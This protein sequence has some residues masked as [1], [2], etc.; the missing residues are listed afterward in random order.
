MRLVAHRWPSFP[1]RG[2]DG[3]G[4]AT[5]K[6]RAVRSFAIIRPHLR[7]AV[8]FYAA[9]VAA[10]VVPI[11]QV[12]ILRDFI[13]DLGHGG[14]SSHR[15]LALLGVF[16]GVFLLGTFMR[17]LSATLSSSL[18]YQIIAHLQ[19][20]MFD[21]LTSMP[22]VFYTSVRPGAVVSRMTNDVNGIEAMY[23]TVLPAIV[24]SIV[25]IAVSLA[26]IA[27]VEPLMLLLVLLV[28]LCL[29]VVRRAEARINGLINE[30]FEVTKQISSSTESLVS[31]E[32]ILLARQNG[33][34]FDERQKFFALTRASSLTSRRISRAAAT[35]GASYNAAFGVMTALSLGVSV[36][37]AHD[38]RL[39]IGDVVMTTLFVQQLQAPVQSL[40]GT[41]YP[42]LRAKIAFDRVFEVL[43]S[44]VR[45]DPKSLTGRGSAGEPLPSPAPCAPQGS[46]GAPA[47]DV[48]LIL[49]A[50]SF[51]YPPVSTYSI[52]G[53]SH[54]G[55]VISIPWLP[56]TGFSGDDSPVSPER[57]RE[58]LSNFDV[59]VKAGQVKAIVGTSGSG[60]STVA[61]LAA[62]L[63]EPT[64]GRVEIC[65]RDVLTLDHTQLAGLVAFITQDTFVLHDSIRANLRY[66]KPDATDSQILEACEAAQLS[67]FLASHDDGL[68]AV[69]GEKGHRLSGGEKQR[70]AIARAL[71]KDPDVV[72]LDEATAHLDHATESAVMAAVLSAF[73]TKAVLVIAHRL[74]TV[75]GA[76]EI[77]VLEHG[78]VVQRGAHH[79]LLEESAGP[80]ARLMT[81]GER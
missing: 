76:D 77:V 28:P 42:R 12:L 30:S 32:G 25:A 64:A 45:P 79:H 40:L 21:R 37:L 63:M 31:R 47:G 34:T 8:G 36:W 62:G 57:E 60:K 26:L 80:Y 11:I 16:C 9:S 56:L 70:L 68:D 6:S 29:L 52:K 38:G 22:L 19:R 3:G 20:R 48:K 49:R 39:S 4:T 75:T 78:K 72:I 35:I 53:L 13:D 5:G 44:E 54:V 7:I 71:L 61:L 67:A 41:R 18:A 65:G 51:T 14:Q 46:G 17:Y 10:A 15:F 58:V 81:A 2:N 23:T 50:V 66:A 24:S 55:E 27:T 73:R 33:R 59:E 69:V 1:R 74:R 43:E